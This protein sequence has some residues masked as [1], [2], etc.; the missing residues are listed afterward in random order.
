MGG[1]K[2]VNGVAGRRLKSSAS[3]RTVLAFSC[4]LPILDSSDLSADI[5]RE[6]TLPGNGAAD[7]A[8]MPTG[9]IRRLAAPVE[10]ETLCELLPDLGSA[11]I[12]LVSAPGPEPRPGPESRGG[13]RPAAGLNPTTANRADLAGARFSQKLG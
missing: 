7:A 6:D 8:A 10:E 13:T 5:A 3:L 4:R 11:D 1:L 12:P 2:E 9:G